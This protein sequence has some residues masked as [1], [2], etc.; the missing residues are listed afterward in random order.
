MSIA[1]VYLITILRRNNIFFFFRLTL[2]VLFVVQLE[3]LDENVSDFRVRV[4]CS[5]FD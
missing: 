5:V 1:N 2:I 4:T 3:F